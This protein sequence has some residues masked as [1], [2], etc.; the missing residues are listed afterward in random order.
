MRYALFAVLFAAATFSQTVRAD[1]LIYQLPDD[2]AQVRFD[3]ETTA[4]VGGQ[5]VAS[6]G[7]VTISSVGTVMVDNE[8]CRWIEIKLITNDDGQEHLVIAKVLVPESH[9]GKGKS[10]GE[11]ILRG[12][13]KDGDAEP[14]EKKDFNVPEALPL[15]V[16]LAGPPREPGKLD[17]VEIDGKLGKLKC[18][19]ATGETEFEFGDGTVSIGFENRLH[20][21]APFGLVTGNWKFEV[22]NNGQIAIAGTFKLTLADT[23]TTALSELPD[24]K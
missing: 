9:L 6:K 17:A 23:S 22:K 18:A 8:K 3:T 20:E 14:Q 5:D 7:S 19:G 11:H 4:S 13:L 21:K 1:G 15:R 16:F 24:K 12:W 10:P 2:G